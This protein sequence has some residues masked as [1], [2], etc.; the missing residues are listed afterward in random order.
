MN[1]LYYERS[2]QLQI[3]FIPDLFMVNSFHVIANVDNR[4][5]RV[6]TITD[7]GEKYIVAHS[8]LFE[9]WYETFDTITDCRQTFMDVEHLILARL[10]E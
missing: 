5:V 7:Y 2:E 1:I 3:S 6:G 4:C 10:G 8:R 9:S